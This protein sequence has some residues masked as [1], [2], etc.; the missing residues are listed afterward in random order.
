M[1]TTCKVIKQGEIMAVII[2]SN[3]Q[4]VMTTYGGDE[5]VVGGVVVVVVVEEYARS[6]KKCVDIKDQLPAKLTW[7]YSMILKPLKITIPKLD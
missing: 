3:S 7:P 1:M 5:V 6:L 2:M 4:I